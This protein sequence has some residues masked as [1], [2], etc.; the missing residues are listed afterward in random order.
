MLYKDN[1]IDQFFL[2]KHYRPWFP[3]MFLKTIHPIRWM[4][5]SVDVDLLWEKNTAEWLTDSG[6]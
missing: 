3:P 6:W 1:T 5:T 4:V 2:E